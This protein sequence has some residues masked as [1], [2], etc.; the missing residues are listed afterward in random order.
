MTKQNVSENSVGPLVGVRVVE[1][2]NM[3]AGPMV[4][5]IL[6]HL[7]AQVTRVELPGKGDQMRSWPPLKGGL[8]LQFARVNAN[9]RS[10]GIDLRTSE[11]QGLARRLAQKADVVVTSYRSPTLKSWGLDYPALMA[12]NPQT[13]VVAVSGFGQSG[14]Y[15]ERPGFG[16]IA[17]A[18][19][20]FAHITG[21]ASTPP[22]FAT[23]GLADQLAAISGALGAMTAL[24]RR[25]ITGVGDLVDVAIYEPLMFVVGD[26]I[27]RYSATG[28]VTQRE[29]DDRA[30]PT[31]AR[32]I[33]E[34]QDGKWLAIASSAD[35][36]VPRLFKAIGRLALLDD[37][38][39]ATNASR[40]ANASEVKALLRDWVASRPRSEALKNLI[41]HGVTAGAVNDAQEIVDDPHF[42]D[43]TLVR[44]DSGQAGQFTMPGYLFHLG[45][46]SGIKHKNVPA[47][48]EHTDRVLATELGLHKAEIERLRAAGVIG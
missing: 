22:T 24:Y 11:G 4:G 20:G 19:S 26:A 35:S 3:W 30:G 29:G 13:I 17:D 8:S 47:V 44:V 16:S 6:C 2:A 9:K 39:F 18:V 28:E 14:P 46:F 43:R 31:G 34:A 45:S 10:V 37:P 40:I 33:F 7:G 32:G 38:R 5:T 27:V 1:V 42:R 21:Y 41:D 15:S 12:L 36:M 48:G 23:F 25:Q